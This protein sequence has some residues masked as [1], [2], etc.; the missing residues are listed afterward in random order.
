VNHPAAEAVLV[1]TLTAKPAR[2]MPGRLA[3]AVR[4]YVSSRRAQSVRE[5][6]FGQPGTQSSDCGQGSHAIF[7]H[8]VILRTKSGNFP[9]NPLNRFAACQERDNIL[10]LHEPDALLHA[11]L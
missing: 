9:Y 7:P 6:L 10:C 3:C 5:S 4:C 11:T 8:P 2:R 1:E